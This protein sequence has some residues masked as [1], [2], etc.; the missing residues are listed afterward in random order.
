LPDHLVALVGPDEIESMRRKI[1]ARPPASGPLLR[2]RDFLEAAA[3]FAMVVL[4]TFPVVLPFVF[5][6][7]VARAMRYSQAITV[8]MLFFAGAALARHAGRPR[9]L[10]TGIGM[11]V[12]GVVLIAAVKAL[13]G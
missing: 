7:D 9:P 5:A 1:V 2:P 10:A 3:V 11:A 4:A 12:F 8:V 13:G 6:D